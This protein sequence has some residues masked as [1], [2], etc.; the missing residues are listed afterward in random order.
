MAE[1]VFTVGQ[2]HSAAKSNGPA[3][4]SAG[5][6]VPANRSSEGA[7]F[8]MSNDQDQAAAQIEIL[9]TKSLAAHY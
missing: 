3:S 5:D 8:E 6:A 1:A 7:R 4:F 2:G 9:V